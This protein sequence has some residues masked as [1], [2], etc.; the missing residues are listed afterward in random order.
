MGRPRMITK[1]SSGP[2]QTRRSDRIR[3]RELD[4]INP[5]IKIG[6][7]EEYDRIN[8]RL[9]GSFDIIDLEGELIESVT[10]SDHGWYVVPDSTKEARAVFSILI[11]AFARREAADKLRKKLSAENHPARVAEVGEEILI[12]R[13]SV[14]NNIKYRVL[15][16]RWQTEREARAHLEVFRD[17]FAPRV[18]R[19]IVKPTK[20]TIELFKDGNTDS[21]LI[22]RGVRFIPLD[23]TSNVLLYAVRDGTGF[24]WER[25]VDR[26]YQGII[27]IR[28]D[29]RALLLAFTELPLEQYLKG[30]VPS[31]MP[32]NYPMEA[33]KAQTVAA[34]SEVL[35]KI[36]IKHLND[37]FDLCGTVHCQV[38]SGITNIHPNSNEA[39]DATR[40]QVLLL[41]NK[42][43]EAVFSSCCGGHTENKVNVWN[44]PESPHLEGYWDFP[45]GSDLKMDSIDLTKELDNDNWVNS[46]PEAWCNAGAFDDIP[47]IL[48]KAERYFRWQVSY[49]H[50]ELEG[51]IRRKL[52]EDIGTL[53]NIIPLK[54][55]VSGRLMEI[56]IQGSKRN[57]KVQRELNIRRILSPSYLYSAC[58]SINVEYGDS[59]RPLNFIF[60]G[61]G[62]GHGVGMCQ[63]GAGIQAAKKRKYTEILNSYYPGTTVKK[64]YGE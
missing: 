20:G 13:K 11:T 47:V 6:L 46:K 40:G 56:E 54:R 2:R 27:E 52:G 18:I 32:A 51:I 42:V 12:E 1:D 53:I 57:I 43:A 34:R 55:G 63:V 17:K 29:H 35:A 59:G 49:S 10:G 15:V 37:P 36:G 22:E 26:T 21:R 38:Y 62:W 3:K 41:N 28:L 58:F 60:K 8:F 25:E 61:A 14:S 19:Q 44:P 45:A 39:I 5:I 48:K 33:L 4:S 16:G 50:R 9:I 64:I 30:V 23:D 7:M 24:H 31:E